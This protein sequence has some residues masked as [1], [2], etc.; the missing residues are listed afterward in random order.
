MLFVVFQN[1]S[2]QVADVKYTPSVDLIA[3][4]LSHMS[5]LREID[6]ISEMLH[7][8]HVIHNATRRYQQ[9]WL[10]L[11]ERYKGN[12]LLL[13]PLDVHW[14]WHVHM[15]CP[16]LYASD[17]DRLVHALPDHQFL[18]GE[19]HV[20]AETAA[21]I[22]WAAMYPEEPYDINYSTVDPSTTFQSNLEY[23]IVAASKRQMLCFYSVSLPHYKDSMFLET[24]LER[25]LKFINLK[26]LN[27]N[28]YLVPM[29]DIDMIWHTHQLSPVSYRSDTQRWLGYVLDHDDSTTDRSPE[30]KLSTCSEQT[31]TLWWDTYGEPLVIA[32]VNFRGESPRGQLQQITR[33]SV[34]NIMPKE[35][36]V[37][38]EKVTLTGV[39]ESVK[40]SGKITVHG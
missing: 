30:S 2:I 12:D 32:G 17:C 4:C 36:T 37:R 34:S 25:Y 27:S 39:K 5:F 10:P 35:V 16:R 11:K 29:Y 6:A 28:A 38:I 24:S 33:D 8:D 40:I 21:K 14:V 26:R 19:E 20:R 15:L 23:D 9:F 1:M 18:V 22:V 13:P 7:R 31:R 3:N